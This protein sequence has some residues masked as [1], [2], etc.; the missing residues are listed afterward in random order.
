MGPFSFVVGGPLSQT[1]FEASSLRVAL[2]SPPLPKRR[3]AVQSD[4]TV[5]GV[6]H[7]ERNGE[8]PRSLLNALDWKYVSRGTMVRLVVS[9]RM[10]HLVTALAERVASR[11]DPFLPVS[12][13]VPNRLLGRWLEMRLAECLGIAANLRFSRIERFLAEQLERF[14]RAAGIEPRPFLDAARLEGALLA[15]LLDD[16]TLRADPDLAPLCDWLGHARDDE[17]NRSRRIAQLA[18]RLAY[19]Y[20]EYDFSRSSMIERWLRGELE[21]EGTRFAATERWQCALYRLVRAHDPHAIGLTEALSLPLSKPDPEGERAAHLIG[22]SYVAPIFHRAIAVL[23]EILDLD[24]YVLR[25]C[26]EGWHDGMR[27]IEEQGDLR[28]RPPQG[29]DDFGP[30]FADI[31]PP[32]W[33]SWGRPGREHAAMLDE[34]TAS[35]RRVV[36]EDPGEGTLL[37]RLQSAMLRGNAVQAGPIDDSVRLIACPSIRREVETLAGEIWALVDRSQTS[38]QPYRF[39]Q[40]AVLVNGANWD[41]YLPHIEAVFAEAR[42]LPWS[43]ADVPLVARSRVAHCALRL[44]ELLGSSFTRAEVLEVITHPLVLARWPDADPGRVAQLF[45]RLGVFHGIDARDHRGTYLETSGLVHWDQALRRLALGAFMEGEKSGASEPFVGE[46][47]ARLFPE[48]VA[49]SDELCAGLGPL[50]RSLAS[51]A[52]FARRARMLPSEWGRFFVALL[53]AYLSP[54]DETEESELR[55][56]IAALGELASRDAGRLID[57]RIA[58]T[59]ARA[60]LEALPGARG[61]LL[62]EGVVVASLRPMRAIPFRAIFVLGLGEG[63]FPARETESGLDLRAA[64]RQPGDVAS[65]E[66][67]RYALLETLLSAREQ[68]VLSWV[69]R[70]EQTGEPREPSSV[71]TEI[72]EAIGTPLPR[73]TPPLRRHEIIECADVPAVA[74][75]AIAAIPREAA[76]RAAGAPYRRAYPDARMPESALARLPLDDELRKLLELPLVQLAAPTSERPREVVSIGHLRRFLECPIQGHA[77][78]A[79]GVEADAPAPVA[80]DEPFEIETL[81]EESVL[82]EVFL[83]AIGE[84]SARLDAVYEARV[85]RRAAQ[86]RW[87]FGP[88]AERRRAV[89]RAALE[90]WLGAIERWGL[91]TTLHRFRFGGGIGGSSVSLERPLPPIAMVLPGGRQ[92]V[93]LIGR[94]E[95]LLP[96]GDLLMTT[97]SGVDKDREYACV[98]RLK[99]ALRA[100]LNHAVLAVSGVVSSSDPR[101]VWI[102]AG[103]GDRPIEMRFAPMSA[104][105]AEKWL[106]GLIEDLLCGPRGLFLPCEAVFRVNT[107]FSH[108]SEN[109]SQELAR[110]IEVVRGDGWSGGSSR[111]G[112][113]RDATEC[114]A[115]EPEQ[116]LEIARRRFGA[117]FEHLEDEDIARVT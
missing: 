79:I 76:A 78:W 4:V 32:L 16:A 88:L 35:E 29:E 89:H 84:S 45:D 74:K 34:I 11:G 97:L 100:F 111:F 7:R 106:A 93:Q 2:G 75:V 53:Q 48:E 72:E 61:E 51:D 99:R 108:D 104:D 65:D 6:R 46:D 12:I 58:I 86:G 52:R 71:V 114:P 82:G 3:S 27:N 63:R 64:R 42:G 49:F 60:E 38:G 33:G 8:R 94:T 98:G 19:L 57:A 47:D 22:F 14:Q 107:I 67:D 41:R 109:A 9:N 44:I 81:E 117:F 102:L 70:D 39:H 69:A 113:V 40:I 13:V 37:R 26:R 116:A 115:P 101:R 24:V 54:T 73:W 23:G 15:V 83:E 112:P 105:A 85:A 21:F 92:T 31:D 50:V 18:R 10:E 28:L 68:W 17:D 56:C 20:Q 87:P 43:T 90:A 95:W 59:L 110:S 25:P 96:N 91:G 80:I 5:S 77:R 62:G 36:F 103:S 30:R 55:R 1:R 66:R